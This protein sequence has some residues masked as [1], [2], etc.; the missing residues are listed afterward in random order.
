MQHGIM[1]PNVTK[2]KWGDVPAKRRTITVDGEPLELVE[3][4]IAPW[5]AG[6]G[7]SLVKVYEVGKDP[8]GEIVFGVGNEQPPVLGWVYP[9]QFCGE[10]PQ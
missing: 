4:G 7:V 10:W 9:H 8:D 1:E 5:L 6:M 3:G 2:L